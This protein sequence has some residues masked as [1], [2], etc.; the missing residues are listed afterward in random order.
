MS[1]VQFQRLKNI[2]WL[3]KEQLILAN[4]YICNMM[5]D[6]DNLLEYYYDMNC[7]TMK[8]FSVLKKRNNVRIGLTLCNN[9]IV[10]FLLD[11]KHKNCQCSSVL[12]NTKI[13]RI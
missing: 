9:E 7:F 5:N 11:D 8:R 13:D 2:E 4:D 12:F 3:T 6:E 1:Y 10:D